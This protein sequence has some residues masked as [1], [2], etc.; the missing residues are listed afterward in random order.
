MILLII[1]FWS[2]EIAWIENLFA[3][4]KWKKAVYYEMGFSTFEDAGF[5]I[6]KD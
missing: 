1:A 4:E 5:L 6:M 2:G 3:L